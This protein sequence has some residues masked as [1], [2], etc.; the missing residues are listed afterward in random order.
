MKCFCPCVRA[1]KEFLDMT[2]KTQPPKEKNA[3]LDFIKLKTSAF[4]RE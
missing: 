3:Q 4:K 2:P 1:D